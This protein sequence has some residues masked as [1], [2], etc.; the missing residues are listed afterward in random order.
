MATRF[1]KTTGKYETDTGGLGDDEKS[2]EEIIAAALKAEGEAEAGSGGTAAAN[3]NAQTAKTTASAKSKAA[4]LKVKND[5]A[6]VDAKNLY[7]RQQNA[8][9]VAQ[10]Q[11]TNKQQ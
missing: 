1:N 2:F 9:A 3:I 10:Q 8:L 7:T 4:A 6:A 5:K 11:K